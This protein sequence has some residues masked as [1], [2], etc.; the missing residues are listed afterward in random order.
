MVLVNTES[1][2]IISTGYNGAASGEAHCIDVGCLVEDGHCQ[3]VI[4][5]EVNAVGQAARWG[6]RVDNAMA[7]VVKLNH[8]E[9][10]AKNGV[11]AC[12]ECRKVLKAANV[13]IH[14]EE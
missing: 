9:D 1:N 6:I 4:H 12:R 3:R 11:G 2:T 8:S 14:G 13:K 7:Y 10:A 5:A